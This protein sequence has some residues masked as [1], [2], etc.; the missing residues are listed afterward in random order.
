MVSLILTS[1][2]IMV[3]FVLLPGSSNAESPE[4]TVRIECAGP[5]WGTITGDETENINMEGDMDYQV[6]GE[7]IYVIMTKASDDYTELKVSIMVDGN[8]RISKSTTDPNGELRMSYSLGAEGDPFDDDGEDGDDDNKWGYICVGTFTMLIILLLAGAL[9]L[10]R[11]R[12][13]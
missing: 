7:I 3:S 9:I 2:L 10:A 12:K 4:A 11:I 8:T 6:K 1:A 5:Y 13:G